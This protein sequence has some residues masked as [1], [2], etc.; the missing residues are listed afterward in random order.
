MNVGNG[1][2]SLKVEMVDSIGAV[3]AFIRTVIAL[4]VKE[5]TL[6]LEQMKEIVKIANKVGAIT[7]QN[8]G[9]FESIP[10]LEEIL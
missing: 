4:A 7:T 9:T 2:V 10:S 5:Q 1:S 8:C 3:D 6:T